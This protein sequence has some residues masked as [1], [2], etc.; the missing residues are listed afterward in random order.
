MPGHRVRLALMA[1]VLALTACG[2]PSHPP[3]RTYNGRFSA[4]AHGATAGNAVSGRF[5][6]E[7]QGSRQVIDLTTPIG[8]TVARIEIE[9]GRAVATGPQLQTTTGPDAET[10][11][12][13]LIGWRLPVSGLADWLEGRPEPTRPARIQ[14]DGSRISIIEQDGWTIRID[15]Y[16]A[17]TSKPR[18]LSM[19]R[20]VSSGQPAVL[21]RLVVDDP[22]G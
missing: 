1:C 8:T 4:T 13:R 14:Y 12:E 5:T 19:E 10:L 18:R 15:E 2:T 7:V 20:P 22:D 16:S 17:A 21:V 9:P 11:V 6:V 3:E